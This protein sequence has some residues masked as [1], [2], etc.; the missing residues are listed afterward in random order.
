MT[1]ARTRLDPK[2]RKRLILTAAIATA[3][4]KRLF[5]MTRLDVAAAAGCSAPLVGVHFKTMDALRDA[6]LAE[7]IKTKDL[8]LLAQG[9]AIAHPRCRRLPADLRARAIADL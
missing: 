4:K 5:N 6:V 9:I 8:A 7:A 2:E 3:K 1:Q